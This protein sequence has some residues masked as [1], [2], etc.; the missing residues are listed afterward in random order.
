M[1]RLVAGHWKL[2]VPLGG[3]LGGWLAPGP[4]AQPKL[5][6]KQ[7]Q[8][9]PTRSACFSSKSSITCSLDEIETRLGALDPADTV[10]RFQSVY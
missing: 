5:P 3:H 1:K 4:F 10:G 2:A 8:Q 6:A 9:Q 7:Q